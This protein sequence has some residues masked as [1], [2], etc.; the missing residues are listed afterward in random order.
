MS[1]SAAQ[2][3]QP[4]RGQIAAVVALVN[5][6]RAREALDAALHHLHAAMAITPMGEDGV[7]EMGETA[8]R[9]AGHL[10]DHRERIGVMYDG[11]RM[12]DAQ[13]AQ[14]GGTQGE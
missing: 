8:K 5:I 12:V 6:G 7:R 10:H 14:K 11:A 1:S 9:L 3:D 13:R 4:E 2:T